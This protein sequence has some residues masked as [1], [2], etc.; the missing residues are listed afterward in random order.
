M[1]TPSGQ[2]GRLVRLRV[3]SP[4]QLPS[5]PDLSNLQAST[6]APPDL[7]LFI[8]DILNEASTFMTSYLPNHFSIKER[9]KTS[10]PAKATV[11]LLAH[12]IPASKLG[13]GACDESWF[14]RTS[15]HENKREPGTADWDEFEAGLF[16][17]H[18][19]HEMEY[20]PDVFDA[21]KVLS[22]DEKLADRQNRIGAWEKVG[23]S[24]K[25]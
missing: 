25:S 17:D 14:A 15:L 5:H 2:Y 1:S 16:D 6:T 23:L 9:S 18:S 4:S 20:T 8:T 24:G 22:W 3:L 7:E 12:E 11:Q 21:H 19:L 13:S 10:P